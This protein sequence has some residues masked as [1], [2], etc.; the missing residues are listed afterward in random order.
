M[1]VAYNK[2]LGLHH[3]LNTAYLTNLAF[4]GN[5]PLA[6]Q[7]PGECARQIP[8]PSDQVPG[9]W[10]ELYKAG[11]AEHPQQVRRDVDEQQAAL[12]GEH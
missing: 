1:C 4:Q 5:V 7:G 8:P 10:L 11:P 3:T 9:D 6:F 12:W 2:K